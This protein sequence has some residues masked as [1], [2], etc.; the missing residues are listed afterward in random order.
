MLNLDM[1]GRNPQRPVDVFGDGFVRGLRDLVESLNGDDL[2]LSFGGAAYAGNSDHDPFYSADVPFV[3]FF[4]GVHDD[5]HQLGDHPDKLDFERMQ[6]IVRLAYALVDRVAA[7]DAAPR[8][9]HNLEWLGTRIEV[10]EVEGE[11][12]AVV[13]GVEA[14]SRASTAGL[15]QG[16]VLVAFDDER[17]DDPDEVG[18][19]FRA[20]DP[21]SVV[22]LTV[23]QAGDERRV[24]VERARTGYLG[25]FPASVDADTR[26]RYGLGDDE[27]ILL[28]QVTDEGP[29]ARGGLKTGDILIRVAGR[30]IGMTSLRARLMQL[31]A[32]ETVPIMVIRDG[33]R[34]EHAVTLGERPQS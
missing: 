26:E 8:F 25:V 21:G 12:R 10:V 28:R 19:R 1:I 15:K 24:E 34:V 29:A 33:E 4:T 13:T 7:M 27:G 23:V 16:D 6:R 30:P 17:L 11:T 18:D 5:Y 9:I 22:V 20:I 14:D 2:A 31:G 3:F 32:G